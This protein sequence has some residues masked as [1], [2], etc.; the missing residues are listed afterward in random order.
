MSVP[1]RESS[2]AG[3]RLSAIGYGGMLLSI[4][5]RPDRADAIALL[6][7][8]L[9]AGVTFIDTADSY[10][11][12]EDDKHHNEGLIHEALERWS[13]D[14]ETITVATKGGL[15]RPEGRW[16]RD[17]R[18][19]RLA[20]AIARSAE[21]LGGTIDL[22]QLHAPD[23]EVPIE[24]SLGPV[25]S[26]VDAGTIRHVG[27]S[28]VTVEEVRRARAILPI[29]SIQNHFNPWTRGAE[30]DGVLELCEREG[31]LFLPWSPF[32]GRHRAKS[33][34]ATFPILAELS[35]EL[36]ASPWQ[37]VLAW[38]L[39]LSPAILPIPATTRRA[40]LESNLQAATLELDEAA[41]ERLNAGLRVAEDA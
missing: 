9:D 35:A 37:L 11:L 24:D 19:E 22:W 34:P 31:L 21:A 25:R 39:R 6:H 28:N 14:R 7:A 17:G 4:T 12:D 33:L 32:G 18:P 27:L 30:S 2:P 38:L 3:L 15:I 1:E 13:G 5:G 8:A 23:P 10:C 40:A 20:T 16:E 36:D 29:V 26:A 41:F